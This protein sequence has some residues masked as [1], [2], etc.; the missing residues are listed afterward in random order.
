MFFI[1]DDSGEACDAPSAPSVP[2]LPELLQLNSGA[3]LAN[4][5]TP[6]QLE[7]MSPQELV[8]L[9]VMISSALQAWIWYG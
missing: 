3:A 4:S 7:R 9:Q 6:H 8:Q 2:Q 5:L 1:G